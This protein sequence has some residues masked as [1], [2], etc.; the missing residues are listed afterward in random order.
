M[1]TL[2][3]ALLLLS[4]S[5]AHAFEKGKEY[6]GQGI[7][8][9]EKEQAVLMGQAEVIDNYQLQRAIDE[10]GEGCGFATFIYTYHSKQVIAVHGGYVAVH[11]V[12]VTGYPKMS[13]LGLIKMPLTKKIQYIYTRAKG[14]GV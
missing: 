2:I 8:C 11:E 9:D 1:R 6:V 5:T 12:E 10:H 7:F 3:L 13:M 4:A 14:H